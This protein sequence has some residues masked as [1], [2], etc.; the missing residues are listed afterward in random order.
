MYLSNKTTSK[1]CFWHLNSKISQCIENL[2]VFNSITVFGHVSLDWMLWDDVCNNFDA[3][4][5]LKQIVL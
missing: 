2:K 1:I 3:L 4:S 5:R